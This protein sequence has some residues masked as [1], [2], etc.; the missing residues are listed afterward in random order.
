L[1]PKLGKAEIDEPVFNSKTLSYE[2]SGK[3]LRKCKSTAYM[4]K[5]S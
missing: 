2:P 5:L 1:D 4:S 3:D